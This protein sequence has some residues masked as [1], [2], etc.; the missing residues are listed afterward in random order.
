MK[1][2]YPAYYDYKHTSKNNQAGVCKK[3]QTGNTE[4]CAGTKRGVDIYKDQCK[5]GSK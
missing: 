4:P 1:H 5:K 2:Y 3:L